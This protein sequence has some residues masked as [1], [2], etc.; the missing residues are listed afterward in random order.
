M[1][2]C[3]EFTRAGV[4][5]EHTSEH[6]SP[7]RD[8]VPMVVQL[9]D[10]EGNLVKEE[11]FQLMVRIREGE[12]NSPPKPSFLSMMMMEVSQ[13]VMTAL[14][15]D[16]LA[17]EDAE[18]DP[19]QLVFNITSPLSYE[20][21]YVVS[22]DDRNLPI[23][24]F[25]QGD[26]RHL[27]IAYKPPSLDSDSERIFQLELQVV[28]TDGAASDPFA[29]M[30]VVKPMNSLAPVVTRNTGQLLYE[31]QS[32][33]LF[34]T[35]NLEI[36]DEDNLDAVSITVVEGL[37]HGDLLVLGSQRK[38]FT[39][40]DLDAGVVVYQHDGSDT[41]S[42]NIVFLMSDGKNQVEFLF[43][44]TIV[45]TDDEPPILNANTGLV[46]FKNQM[47]PVSPL[48]LSAADIDSEDSTIRFS[49]IPP[50]S[51]VGAVLLRQSDAPE[52]PSS[53]KFNAEDEMYEKEVREWL[54]KD[55]TEGRLFYRHTGP[56]NSETVLDQFAFRVRDD[57]D[58]PNESGEN[59]FVVRILPIDDVPPEL[60][61]GTTLQMSVQE[62]KLTH[63]SKEVLRYTDADSEDRDLKY[64]VIQPP[65]DTDENNP[66]AFGSLVLTDDPGREVTE[67]TQAQINHHKVSYSPPDVELGITPHIAQFRYTVEDAAG[68]SAEGAL[69]IYLQP[70]NNNPPQIT[71]TGLTVAER[72]THVI[73]SAELDASDLDT[74][75][76]RISFALR[77]PPQHGQ[78]QVALAHLEREGLA[79]LEREGLFG[80]ADIAGGRVSYRHGGDE[81]ASDEFQLDV[82]DGVHV[83]TVT[84]RVSVKPVDD[85]APT[86]SLP[87]GT[88]GSHVDVLEN[89]ATEITSQVIRGRDA[90]T[91]DLQLTFVLEE[92]PALGEILV[93]GAPAASF[94]QADVING[95]VAYAHTGGEIGLTTQRDG[96]NLTLTDMSDHWTVGGNKVTGVHVQVTVLPVDSQAP[97]VGLGAGFRVLEGQ[98]S[99]IGPQHL[100]A[101]DSDT[102]PADLLCTIMVQPTAGY[103]ENASPA[104]GSEKSRSGTA[105]SAFT[106]GDIREG[107]IYY[108]QS[109]HQGVEPVEDGFTFRCSDGINFSQKNFFPVLIIAANDETPEI[110]VRELVV[111]EGMNV[112]IDTPVLN[113]ADVDFPP[114]ELLF[115]ISQPPKH[116]AILNQLPT[117]SVSVSNFT[118]EQIREASS[119]IYEHDDSETTED[120]FGVTLTDGKFSVQKTATVLIIAVDDETPRMLVN[121]GLEVEMGETKEINSNVLKATDLDSEDGALA[122]VVR[123]GPGQG[124]L[125][126]RKASSGSLENITLGMNFTQAEVDAGLISYAHSGQ[127]GIRDL[128][129]FDVTDGINPLVD[130]YFY[131]TVGGIDAV[132]PD[133][134]SRGVSLR[135]GGRVTLTTDLLSTTDLN[136]PDEHLAFT[137]TR[138]P[139]RGHLEC[140]DSPGRPV[141]SFTQ[142]QLAGSKISYIHTSDDEVKMDS[143]EFEVTDGFN[144]IF[145]TFRVSIVDVDNKKPVVTVNGLVVEEGR[146]KLITPFELTA[147]DQDTDEELLSF[148][149]TQLPLHGHLLYNG[150][151]PTA[152]FTKQDLN[153]NLISYKHDGTESV[154]DS[155]SFTVTDGTHAEFYVFPDTVFETRRPQTLEITIVAL[156]NGVPQM[157]VNKGATTLKTLSVGHL[158][159]PI[160][161][162]VLRA[163]DRDSTPASLVFRITGQPKHGYI[164]N[165]GRGNDSVDTFSQGKLASALKPSM[166]LT[167]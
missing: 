97:E 73:S 155:F 85:E 19:D 4:R 40:D 72:S 67:F 107:N 46:L 7:N 75:S 148:T 141:V 14:T 106:I 113:G 10:Q 100:N 126:R 39:P 62:F 139:V 42:D 70:V 137:I 65:T 56:H 115:I 51:K 22:T 123:S 98:K 36:S 58:P 157:L 50:F 127:E 74:P 140:S 30:I 33:P 88:V 153:E 118:L 59:V 125:L 80:L 101:D 57:N 35:H 16:M 53:W 41:Y 20:E 61:P 110:Y 164:A 89:G 162:K 96:F 54:Q 142:L 64:T 5:Y 147:E 63:F 105:V 111:M 24:S 129:K 17:A 94:T 78:L 135:E 102:P 92:P 152:S 124:L 150:S 1:M 55:I 136:S 138:A 60:F 32:R 144:P 44:V 8:F 29:F 165:I 108:V 117:G 130:R 122:Y 34:S 25:L 69:T 84:V 3:G 76:G 160:T 134:V 91:D 154:H 143:F 163:E 66:V 79:H 6:K 11:Y 121:D 151:R 133:V 77:R 132:F 156:D 18:S 167:K 114:E 149:V 161:S 2:D 21:G 9:H 52:D 116:G 86:L 12:E 23:T 43:P 37:R 131:V 15:P 119:I 103:V 87:A 28:D 112:V 128:I 82:S 95:A 93:R 38:S 109:I 120:S 68:N 158:G 31:G 48:V 71:N 166:C 47:M 159:F 146:M 81:A 145:R 27:K 13:F 90:D 83:V 99:S 26:L 45:P 49:V 104:P